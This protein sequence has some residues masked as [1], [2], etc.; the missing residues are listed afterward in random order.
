MNRKSRRAE[1]C[2]KQ[3]LKRINADQFRHSVAIRAVTRPIDPR[4]S[5]AASIRKQVWRNQYRMTLN[6]MLSE[7]HASH[8]RYYSA[9]EPEYY[10]LAGIF[11]G[12]LR[13]RGL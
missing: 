9:E 8:T 3:G 1:N 2:R 4:S 13:R 7:L 10:Q 11:A 12:A 5:Y 6:D